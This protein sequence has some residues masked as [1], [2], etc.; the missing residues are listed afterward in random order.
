[1]AASVMLLGACSSPHLVTDASGQACHANYAEVKRQYGVHFARPCASD[2]MA[3]ENHLQAATVSQPEN[4]MSSPD[5]FDDTNGIYTRQDWSQKGL[6]YWMLP[7]PVMNANGVK[8]ASHLLEARW[9][10]LKRNDVK[11][12]LY[13]DERRDLSNIQWVVDGSVVLERVAMWPAEQVQG[14]QKNMSLQSF[15]VPY[16]VLKN[17]AMAHQANLV[18]TYANGESTQVILVQQGEPSPAS[19]GLRRLFNA[20]ESH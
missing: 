10:N 13:D 7:Y 15:D 1:M 8:D 18:L 5:S 17:T 6:Y 19:A 16:N 2:L 11:L 12:F 3:K 4:L 20:I 14:P 9:H